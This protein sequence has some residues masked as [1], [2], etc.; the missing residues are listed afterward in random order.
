[1]IYIAGSLFTEA[2]IEQRKKEAN[3]LRHKLQELEIETVVFNPIENPFNDKS[4]Q[5]QAI[6]I[7]KG[8]YRA[9]EAAK[10]FLFNLDNP[11]D[12]GVFLELGQ[13]LERD[14]KI[15]P[16]VSDIRMPNAGDYEGK[17]VPYGLNQ[18]VI[19]ALDYYGLKLYTSSQEA[20]DA[21]IEEIKKDDR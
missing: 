6:D 2:E 3:Y 15:F 12:A 17:Y 20:M 4:S 11:L 14:K 21:M 10:Y 9:M 16:V 18:Y 5:P 1:M 13:M 8:D 7:F 19:G